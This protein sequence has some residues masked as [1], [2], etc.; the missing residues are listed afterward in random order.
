MQAASGLVVG[1]VIVPLLS[2]IAL[3]WVPGPCVAASLL[4]SGL[5]EKR[6]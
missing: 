1:L 2:L 3:D 5:I 6:S 4:L